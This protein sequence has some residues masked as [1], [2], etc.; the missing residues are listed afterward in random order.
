M[1]WLHS[2]KKHELFVRGFGKYT[3]QWPEAEHVMLEEF[4]RAMPQGARWVGE[5]IPEHA[6]LVAHHGLTEAVLLPLADVLPAFLARCAYSN[7]TLEPW[8]G[9]EG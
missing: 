3:K 9:R 6:S 8:Y 4:G 7:K 2:T 1:L 5:L